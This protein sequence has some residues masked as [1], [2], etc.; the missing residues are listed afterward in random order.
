MRKALCV[1]C[2]A[3]RRLKRAGLVLRVFQRRGGKRT[4]ASNGMN[5]TERERPANSD[6]RTVGGVGIGD[7][8]EPLRLQVADQRKQ[9]FFGYLLLKQRADLVHQRLHL[10]R[11][12]V[13]GSMRSQSHQAVPTAAW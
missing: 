5:E 10:V 13:G 8:D 2:C 6:Q 7:G 11:M 12:Y 1:D 3:V 9:F 4:G